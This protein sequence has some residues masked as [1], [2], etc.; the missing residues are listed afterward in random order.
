MSR[1]RL[2][3]LLLALGTLVVFLPV[4]SFQFINYDDDDYVTGNVMVANNERS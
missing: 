3:A 4:G 1:P 2:I